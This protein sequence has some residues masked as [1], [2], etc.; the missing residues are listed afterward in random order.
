MMRR[1][2]TRSRGCEPQSPRAEERCSLGQSIAVISGL[3][4]LSWAV[5]IFAVVGIRALV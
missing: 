5:V 3:S 1:L 4:A 2:E